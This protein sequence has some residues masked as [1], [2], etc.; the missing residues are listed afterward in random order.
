MWCFS[1]HSLSPAQWPLTCLIGHCQWLYIHSLTL[2]PFVLLWGLS[3]NLYM[4]SL[5]ERHHILR[6]FLKSHCT[7]QWSVMGKTVHQ[8]LQNLSTQSHYYSPQQIDK[9]M[10]KE[11]YL[12]VHEV[13]YYIILSHIIL[14]LIN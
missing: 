1:L 4:L 2:G 13:G 11:D 3:H 10:C 9:C 7:V 6:V 14:I 12:V 5:S 8:L